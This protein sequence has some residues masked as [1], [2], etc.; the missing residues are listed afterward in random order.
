MEYRVL[1]NTGLKVSR[2]GLGTAG[3][4]SAELPDAHVEKVLNEALA[5]GI[6]FLDT[7]ALYGLSEQRIGRLLTQRKDEFTIAT[8]CGSYWVESDGR[9]EIAEDYTRE[10][11]LRTV[12]QSRQKL[13]VDMIDLVQF[14]GLPP[15]GQV[16]QAFEVLLGLRERGWARFVGVSADGPA[17]GAF[18]GK[19]TGELDAAE[20]VRQWPV[21]TWQFTYNFLSQEAVTELIPAL[22][23]SG[24]GTIVKR[25]ISNVVWDLKEEPE[26]DF[27]RKPWQRARQLPLEE[28]AGDLS[29]VE[30]ALHFTLSHADVDTAL[31]GSTNSQHVA[32]AVRFSK[33]GP[34]PDET[35][36]RA[37]G[38]FDGVRWVARRSRPVSGCQAAF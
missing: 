28:L 35:L 15:V 25:P 34:L 3:L 14:H 8:K 11:I 2:I 22:Q 30:F 4:G 37:R 31:L 36:E 21:D 6:N 12:D 18:V 19:P 24:V 16:E 38:L 5:L 13:R 20:L 29:M 32:E 10:G 7:A 9:R 1:G 33:R 23:E 26:D 17:A 27:Y